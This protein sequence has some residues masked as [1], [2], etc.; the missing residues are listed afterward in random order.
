[1]RWLIL[2]LCLLPTLAQSQPQ[3]FDCNRVSYFTDECPDKAVQPPAP[4]PVPP[5]PERLTAETAPMFTPE[6]MAPDVPPLM[7]QL[8]Q[9]PTE[10]NA[11]E[12]LVWHLNKMIKSLEMEA[13][14]SRTL[15]NNPEVFEGLN[16][17]LMAALAAKA[18][19]SGNAGGIGALTIPKG[20]LHG[21]Q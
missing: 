11:K 10:E 3:F 14:I 16:A 21:N 6:L 20:L 4:A 19:S 15:A 12:F 2:T 5:E 17:R 7:V 13:L 9:D 1:M 18:A 8:A